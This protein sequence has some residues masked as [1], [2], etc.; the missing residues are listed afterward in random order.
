MWRCKMG[1]DRENINKNIQTLGIIMLCLLLLNALEPVGTYKRR[2]TGSSLVQVMACRM[3]GHNPPQ[4]SMMTHHIIGTLKI[5]WEIL[6]KM[7]KF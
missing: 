7:P 5:T 3:F 6:M 2:W 4:Q 1:K